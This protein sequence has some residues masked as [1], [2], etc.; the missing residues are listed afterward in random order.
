LELLTYLL[1]ALALNLD[2]FGAGM[3]YGA[4]QIK[5]PVISLII[6]SLISV[7]AI[8]ISMLGG[9][10]LLSFIP[11]SLAHRFG[12]VLLLLVGLWVLFQARQGRARTEETPARRTPDG[13]V[14][15]IY[16]RPLGLV[17]RVLKEPT[18]ADL[19]QSGVISPAEA[20]ILGTALAMDA[21]GAGFAVSILGFSLFTTALVVG[22]GH[23][24]LAYLGLLAGRTISA[25]NIGRRLTF[26]P[27]CILIFLGL[28]K[29]C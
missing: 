9:R 11:V 10:C 22:I 23:F 7:A 20:L 17:I 3:A 14:F 16:I 8:C 25:S 28:F 12:G 21:F 6:I 15:E 1:F 18:L 4:R 24:S 2:S 5:V 27:G 13:K 26:L 19:D 29:I